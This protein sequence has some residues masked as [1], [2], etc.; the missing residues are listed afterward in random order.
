MSNKCYL[1]IEEEETSNFA[2]KFNIVQ[3]GLLPFG[4]QRVLQ[5]LRDL[6]KIM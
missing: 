3:F 5:S 2:R 4:V 1:C 6:K